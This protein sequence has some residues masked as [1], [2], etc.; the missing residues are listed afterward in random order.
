MLFIWLKY[1]YYIC[2]YLPF[3]IPKIKSEVLNFTNALRID[4]SFKFN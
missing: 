1:V 3:K 2:N 4:K